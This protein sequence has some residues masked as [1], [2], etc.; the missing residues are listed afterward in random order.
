MI[1][2]KLA[3]PLSQDNRVNLCTAADQALIHLSSSESLDRVQDSG[4]GAERVSCGIKVEREQYL[5]LNPKNKDKK[6]TFMRIEN[7]VKLRKMVS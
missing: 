1:F 5:K 6:I 4:R 7:I 3:D 2:W